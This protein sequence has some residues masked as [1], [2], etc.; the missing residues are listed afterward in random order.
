MSEYYTKLESGVERRRKMNNSMEWSGSLVFT[1]DS[2]SLSIMTWYE[3][4]LTNTLVIAKKEMINGIDE[5]RV[6]NINQNF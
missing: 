4:Y 5:L 3:I 2:F 1:E 6:Q